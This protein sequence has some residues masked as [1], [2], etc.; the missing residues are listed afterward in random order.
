MSKIKIGDLTLD[1]K[2]I[3]GY[4]LLTDDASKY[5]MPAGLYPIVYFEERCVQ[6]AVDVGD[7]DFL[8][9]HREHFE[10][11]QLNEESGDKNNG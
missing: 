3:I 8:W 11:I 4:A 2:Y 10:W 6:I 5:D 1:T 9:I 7:P